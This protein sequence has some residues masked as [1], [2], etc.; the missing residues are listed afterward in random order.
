MLLDVQQHNSMD[1]KCNKIN[2][3]CL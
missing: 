1:I 2:F 3:L